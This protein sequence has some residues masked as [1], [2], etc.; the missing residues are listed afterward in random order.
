MVQV[1]NIFRTKHGESEV[2]WIVAMDGVDEFMHD[3]AIKISIMM[4]SLN[5]ND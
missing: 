2:V 1:V 3:V 5:P 4:N